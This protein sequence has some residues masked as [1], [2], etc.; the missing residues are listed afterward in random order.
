MLFKK[1][2][3]ELQ[4]SYN[5]VDSFPIDKWWLSNYFAGNF[6]T[7]NN[8]F[9]LSLFFILSLKLKAQVVSTV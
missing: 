2:P 5:K 7:F 3:I 4:L 8:D 9:F 6:N 1:K